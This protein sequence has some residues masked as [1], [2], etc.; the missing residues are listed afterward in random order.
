MQGTEGRSTT[1]LRVIRYPFGFQNSSALL[2]RY[3]DEHFIV[4]DST[5]SLGHQVFSVA[6]EY[7]YYLEHRNRLAF[8]CDPVYPDAQPLDIER[9]ANRFA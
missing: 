3:R 2:A 7:G 8:A 6:H 5:R 1:G 4:V 9:W